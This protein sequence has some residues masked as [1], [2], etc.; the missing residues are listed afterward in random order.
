MDLRSPLGKVK[1]ASHAQGG[2]HHWIA[3]RLTAIA[4]IPLIIWFVFNL[5]CSVNDDQAGALS[6]LQNPFNA[7]TMVLFLATSIYHGS[8]GMRVVFED[9]IS[10]SVARTTAIILTNFISI[11]LVVASIVA[12]INLHVSTSQ[13]M[14]SDGDSKNITLTKSDEAINAKSNIIIK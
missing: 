7:I 10:C 8:L 1:D 11:I 13:I 2:S 12:V 5:V 9:Y 3:Q 14:L 4:L 6:F